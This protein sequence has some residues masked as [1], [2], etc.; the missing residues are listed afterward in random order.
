MDSVPDLTVNSGGRLISPA[1]PCIDTKPPS[2]LE[3]TWDSRLAS[4]M[5]DSVP[6]ESD[7]ELRKRERVLTGLKTMVLNWVKESQ[8]E[9]Q[10]HSVAQRLVQHTL[11]HLP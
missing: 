1:F 2:N 11:A 10:A 7:A 5:A 6:I 9:S 4:F 8:P 3:R